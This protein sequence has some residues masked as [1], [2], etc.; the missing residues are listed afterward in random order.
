MGDSPPKQAIYGAAAAMAIKSSDFRNEFFRLPFPAVA[1]TGIGYASDTEDISYTVRAGLANIRTIDR[2]WRSYRGNSKDEYRVLDFGCGTGRLL[3]FQCEFGEDITTIGCEVNPM[4]VEW[5]RE[6]FPCQVDLIP[7]QYDLSF[8]EKPVDLI[9]AWSIF[10]HFSEDEHIRWLKALMGALN[11]GGL[12]IATFKST[13]KLDRI[14]RDAEY[15]RLSRADTIDL[16]VLRKQADNGF[17]F[18]DCYDLEA[19]SDHGIDAETFGQAYISHEYIRDKWSDFG[20]VVAI[21]VAVPDWQ[22]LVVLRR[23]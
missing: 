23:R 9:Y 19:S 2:F 20:E 7:D 6:N 15:R 16:S 14:E 10:T 22:D 12:L 3:R 21:D 11:P 4:A 18:F 1:G 13:T 5:L 17:A 8:L